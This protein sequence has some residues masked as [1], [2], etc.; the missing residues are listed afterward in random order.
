MGAVSKLHV[1]GMGLKYIYAGFS[2]CGTKTMAE[3][4]KT[5][6]FVVYDFQEF[7]LY[8]VDDWTRYF[9]TRDPIEKR[10]TLQK[11][12]ANVDVVCDLPHHLFWK[13]L[14]DA[15]PEA[16]VVFWKRDEAAWFKSIEQQAIRFCDK[17][18]PLPDWIG[19]SILRLFMP[20]MWRAVLYFRE[21]NHVHMT[22]ETWR[23]NKDWRGRV[24][25]PEPTGMIRM[26]RQHCTDVV[27]NCP[28]DK[29]LDL[30]DINCGWET[31]CKFTDKPI[32]SVPWPHKNK[33]GSEVEVILGSPNSP[34]VQRNMREAKQRFVMFSVTGFALWYFRNEI[35]GAIHGS[36]QALIQ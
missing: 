12:Y 29:L 36:I 11:M 6:G 34:V 13:E 25:V 35:S 1:Y 21:R 30:T 16:K 20:T 24:Y 32:P 23:F 15:F 27:H 18:A 3:V 14:L 10:K 26:Y 17:L 5:L 2:K 33:A 19:D 31:I 9:E 4:F 22:G 7:L 8:C 28:K